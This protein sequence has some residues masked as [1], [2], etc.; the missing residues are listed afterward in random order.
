MRTSCQNNPTPRPSSS[1]PTAA[2]RCLSQKK[3]FPTQILGGGASID[4][5][6][7]YDVARD[8][9]FLINTVVESSLSPI[10]VMQNWAPASAP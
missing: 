10:V 5:G 6:R 7:Q 1:V 8:G 9:R 4:I 3:L 2:S